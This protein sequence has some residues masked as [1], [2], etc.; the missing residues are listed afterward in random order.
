MEIDEQLAAC[1]WVVQ[2][3]KHAAVATAQGVAVREV[4]T[5]A[6]PAD[7][8]LFVDRQAVGV[9]EAKKA[10]STLTGVEPQTRKYQVSSP[11]WLPAFEVDGAL[12]FGYESTGAETRFTCGLD[13]VPASRRVFTF[14]RPEA[15]AHWVDEHVRLGDYSTLRA[16][17]P[18]LPELEPEAPG[19]WP[20][21]AEAIRNLE[22]SL[23]E[24]R[25][26]A[27]IQM[28][29][30]AGKTFTAA[31]VCYRLVRH[32]GARRI[33]FLVDR[34]NLGRQA[35]REFEDFT[36]PDD[37]RKFT[38]L[39]N[40][41]RLATSRL[42]IADE[43]ATKVHV[44]TIQR[45][46]S[47]L[48]G[49]DDYDESLDEQTGFETAPD[50]PVEVSYNPKVPIEFYDLIIIDECHRSIYGVWRQVLEY[51]DAFLVGLTATPGIQTF[52]FFDQNMV[53]EYGHEQA[54]ADRVNVDFDVFRIR[55]ELT[56]SGGTVPAD[57]VTEFRDRETRRLRL[58]KV[59]EDIDYNA[60]ELDRKVVALDQIRTVVRTLRESLPAIF[61]D[62]ERR[63][64]GLLKHIPKTL[65][66]AKDDSHADD[67]VQVV[68]QE[69]GLSNEG[70]V[71]ITYKSGDSGNKPEDLLQSF[72]TNYPT[73]IAVTVDMIATGTDVKPIE[74]VVFMRMVRS[75]N[76]FEQ[77]KG[78][79]VRVIDNND[80]RAVTPDAKVKDR[81]VIVDA[82]GVTD[83]GLHDTVPLERKKGVSFDRLLNQIGVGSTDES[84]VSSVASRLAR[85]NRRIT[86]EDRAAVEKVAGIGLDDLVRQITDAL[87]PDRQH[88]EAVAETGTDDPTPEQVKATAERLIT[89]AVQP[90]AGNAQLRE[91]LI[92][93]RRS[94]EQ[95]M[96]TASKD[97]VI[98]GEYSKDAADRA[99]A[100]TESFRQFIE[101]HKDEITAL[102]VL[103]SQP[104][105]GGLTYTDIRELAE[106]IGRPPHRWTP[107]AL[108][109]TYETL[110]ASKVRGSGHRVST[111][112]VSLVRHTLGH[113]DELIAYPDLVNERFEAWLHQ[114]QQ[115]L[116]RHFTDEQTAYLHLIK[117]HIAASLTVAPADLQNPPFST[118]GGLG[119]ARQ[120]FGN[121][122]NPLLE[123]LTLALA[124]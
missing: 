13:P 69:F 44:S 102:Q 100:Q 98:S 76:F 31:N 88:T 85:L 20:A 46:Y 10:G 7:Y 73:R 38:E 39:Y 23:R 116:G 115:A 83:A 49:D 86:A 19:L 6:G 101:D 103:Y 28:A 109:Q 16:G 123:E 65:I 42:D 111:D 56:E 106:A 82:V 1:G 62:R 114:Q 37:R 29:T 3:Y 71:K 94:Y 117:E 64:D 81:F 72:R 47:I 21:Q 70:A 48:R 77:M 107:E 40:V 97:K 54:V 41:R 24:N 14:H 104:Y 84:V 112:L 92:D 5:G 55:T 99:R 95:V 43:T 58:E 11:D 35:V 25:P 53:M 89:E 45:L 18:L 52:A 93:I 50:Q 87:D 22:E 60:A 122:L 121:D 63:D 17:L 90:I 61:D 51:F 4:P 67:I 108:W 78:R 2:D 8:V 9:I 33:L 105:G 80:L 74:C 15:L 57:F 96:D 113:T 34:A 120:L 32:A 75:R 91:K 26:R 118:H 30:G 68:R 119:R 66:F 59:D 36:V 12:P 79:G 27:L 124:A 110:D